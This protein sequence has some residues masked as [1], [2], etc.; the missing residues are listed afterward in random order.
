MRRGILA[1]KYWP[2]VL[3]RAEVRGIF[4]GG[5]VA[6]GIGFWIGAKAHA[7]NRLWDRNY[8]WICFM[9]AKRLTS[10]ELCQHEL[11]H[12]IAGEGSHTRRWRE[13]LLDLG[14]TLNAVPGILRSYQPK[15][16]PK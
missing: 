11:A 15:E 8:G 10:V 6:R 5:C 12:L 2:A 16:M 13:F 9:S 3:Q 1:R 14:G 4:I 7:H